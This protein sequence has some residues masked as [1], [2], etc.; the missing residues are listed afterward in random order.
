MEKFSQIEPLVNVNI[1]STALLNRFPS[2]QFEV[3]NHTIKPGSFEF[4]ENKSRIIWNQNFH[5]TYYRAIRFNLTDKEKTPAIYAESFLNLIHG[6]DHLIAQELEASL[7]ASNESLGNFILRRWNETELEF[8]TIC[9]ENL[10]G[11]DIPII[12]G[13]EKENRFVFRRR[14]IKTKEHQFL[15]YEYFPIEY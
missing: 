7:E 3:L 9:I 12:F 4:E 2:L 13:V 15:I 1:I 6:N 5:S 10:L 8:T 11:K 14:I